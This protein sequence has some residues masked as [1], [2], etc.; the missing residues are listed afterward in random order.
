MHCA[1][2]LPDA[3]EQAGSRRRDA[4]ALVGNART[5]SALNCNFEACSAR[6]G[7]Y[8]IPE[9]QSHSTADEPQILDSGAQQR[10]SAQD[11]NS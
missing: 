1:G 11:D 6:R 4:R 10:A 9:K 7:V 8:D 2:G 5:V 3:A